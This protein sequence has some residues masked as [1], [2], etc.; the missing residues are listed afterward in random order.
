M[1]DAN[2]ARVLKRLDEEFSYLVGEKVL[3]G[4]TYNEGSDIASC[5][6]AIAN[7]VFPSDGQPSGDRRRVM[8]L[9]TDGLSQELDA[10]IKVSNELRSKHDTT[11]AILHTQLDIGLTTAGDKKKSNQHML[12]L[13]EKLKLVTDGLYYNVSQVQMTSATTVN[14]DTVGT[15]SILLTM[16]TLVSDIQK[17]LTERRDPGTEPGVVIG[18]DLVV[19]SALIGDHPFPLDV[20]SASSLSKQLEASSGGAKP[21]TLRQELLMENHSMRYFAMTVLET[22]TTTIDDT[23]PLKTSIFR[24][25]PHRPKSILNTCP[26]QVA[27][28]ILRR[29]RLYSGR[30]QRSPFVVRP[31]TSPGCSKKWC[32]PRTNTR[33]NRQVS[34]VRSS[35]CRDSS[36]RLSQVVLFGL[37]SP[38]CGHIH[39][40]VSRR[41]DFAYKKIFSTRTAG[42]K[43]QYSV[44]IALDI[45]QS[46]S[47]CPLQSAVATF[48]M[49]V[50][51][52]LDELGEARSLC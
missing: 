6:N 17:R 4:F 37:Q 49:L 18:P 41:A 29:M 8:V 12:A 30:T 5:V 44:A 27:N 9:I 51:G 13:Q 50:E 38:I 7:S 33:A 46:M 35:I 11:I 19:N 16:K 45:S 43:R 26:V 34:R 14:A 39:H 2:C 24:G 48:V 10:L 42:G 1:G 52:A 22:K 47:G 21:D 40:S 32:S 15:S 3:A 23:A 25:K 31:K 36:K 20:S 28:P